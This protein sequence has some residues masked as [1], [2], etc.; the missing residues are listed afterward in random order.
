[1]I[2]IN[3]NW[4]RVRITDYI[5]DVMLDG[6]TV[7]AAV[8]YSAAELVAQD[9]AARQ[10][11]L[12]MIEDAVKQAQARQQLLA[13]IKRPGCYVCGAPAPHVAH[14]GPLCPDHYGVWKAWKEAQEDTPPQVDQAQ[15]GQLIAGDYFVKQQAQAK[16]GD[17]QAQAEQGWD[18]AECPCGDQALYFV[19]AANGRVYAYCVECWQ[20]RDAF[21]LPLLA[22][23]ANVIRRCLGRTSGPEGIIDELRRIEAQLTQEG[24]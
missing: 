21:T 15:A 10:Q 16:Q 7:A 24:W 17:L 2:E 3:Y 20:H 4:T 5:Y 6:E 22:Q 1:M 23:C 11:L 9:V 13:M 19:Q 12:A 8:N 18:Y 14:N